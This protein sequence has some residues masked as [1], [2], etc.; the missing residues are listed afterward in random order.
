MVTTQRLV[1]KKRLFIVLNWNV[2]MNSRF[3]HGNT[4]KIVTYMPRILLRI[5]FK[6]FRAVIYQQCMHQQIFSESVVVNS[7]YILQSGLKRLMKRL[8]P[9]P[10]S[11]L[12]LLNQHIRRYVII[13]DSVD[14]DQSMS[15]G[16]NVVRTV[17]LTRRIRIPVITLPFP[18]SKSSFL[19]TM[20]IS[21]AE[22]RLE[23]MKLARLVSQWIGSYKYNRATAR[24]GDRQYRLYSCRKYLRLLQYHRTQSKLSRS[25]RHRAS[26]MYVLKRYE[27][28]VYSSL[29]IRKIVET[30]SLYHHSQLCKR[31][32]YT[33]YRRTKILQ[34]MKRKNKTSKKFYRNRNSSLVMLLWQSHCI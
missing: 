13:G 23:S 17:S 5:H 2:R 20:L 16:T 4:H 34:K 21:R 32:V 22:K 7:N 14:H 1:S 27:L 19:L 28:H 18:K 25:L 29:V 9:S 31:A 33:W 26:C 8:L 11:H 12:K 6:K 24:R 15:T 3:K 30:A 10:K